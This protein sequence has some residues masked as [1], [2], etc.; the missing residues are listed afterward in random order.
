[1]ALNSVSEDVRTM[2]DAGGKGTSGLDLFSFQWGSSIDGDEVDSQI[3]V[4]DTGNIEAQVK[5]EYENPTINI[6]V[7][8]GTSE[9]FKAVHDRARDIYEYMIQQ[10]RQTL[11]GTEYVEFAP[12][13]DQIIP[14]GKDENNRVVYTMN[15][16]TFRNSI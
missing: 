6:M 13:V 3:L 15:F 7:R 5:D 12:I 4:T 9:G 8:G 10:V 14:I 16:Y 2:L 1:M 11:N